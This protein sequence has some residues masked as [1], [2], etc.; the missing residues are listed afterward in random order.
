MA[1]PVTVYRWDDPGAP[2]L[3][4]GKP[5]EVIDIWRKCLVSGYGSKLPLGWTEHFHDTVNQAIAFKNNLAEGGSGSF[6]KIYSNDSSDNNNA[7]M[8][9]TSAFSMTD[10][11]TLFRQG[12]TKAFYIAAGTGN[13][14]N[15]KWILIGTPT[16]FYFLTARNVQNHGFGFLYNAA[17]YCGDIYTTVPNDVGRF[18]TLVQ[19]TQGDT[20][21]VNYTD[22][23]NYYIA[24]ISVTSTTGTLN[25]YDTD[26]FDNAVTYGLSSL[27]SSTT[28]ISSPNFNGAPVH[29]NHRFPLV[30]RRFG[31]NFDSVS[32]SH[33]DR[34][35]EIPARSQLSPYYRGFLPGMFSTLYP[36]YRSEPWPTYVILDG[37]NYL[38][39]QNTNDGGITLFIN[40]ELWNDPNVP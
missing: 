33:L 31:M 9:I 7:L 38:P 24:G 3:V 18:I 1:Q 2:Q 28:A 13:N 37:Q 35:G 39:L 30:I 19:P 27:N 6:V 10:I 40:L 16:G 4:N 36:G 12:F 11:N 14:Y 34:V 21:A 32:A 25:M 20:A 8:R 23:L 26:G 5:S 22:S 29:P 15:N 17:M